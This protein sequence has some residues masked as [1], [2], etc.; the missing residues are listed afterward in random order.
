MESWTPRVL[1]V[2]RIVTA[3]L[4]MEH[5]L[6]KLIHFPVPQPGVP[7][8]L[9]ALLIAA[10]VI[11]IGGGILLTLGLFTRVAAF[12]CSGQ[13]AVA[14]FTAHLPTSFWPGINGGGEAIL[15]SFFFLYLVFAG[16]GTWSL[17]ALR[18]RTPG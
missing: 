18:Q 11:E 16:P 10:A 7:D 14:Y 9:P 1:S 13:M 5:G 8:P 3:L 4:F 2:V 12:I 6:M 17:D 15:Y